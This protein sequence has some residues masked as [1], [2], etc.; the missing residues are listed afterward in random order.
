M[1]NKVRKRKSNV[2]NKISSTKREPTTN[3][4]FQMS[5]YVLLLIFFVIVSFGY[6]FIFP[7][8]FY[9]NEDLQPFENE[10]PMYS[11]LGEKFWSSLISGHYFGLKSSKPNSSI[12]SF[13]WFRNGMNLKIRHW[14]DQNDRLDKY[15]WNYNDLF[16]FGDQLIEDKNLLFNTSFIKVAENSIKSRIIVLDTLKYKYNSIIIYCAAENVHDRIYILNNSDNLFSIKVDGVTDSYTVNINITKGNSFFQSYL[17]TNSTMDQLH[18]TILKNL[19]IFSKN[20]ERLFVISNPNDQINPKSTFVAFQ[21]IFHKSIQIDFEIVPDG[22]SSLSNFNFD[23]KLKFYQNQF[24]QEFEE[25]FSLKKNSYSLEKIEFA[26]S[27]LSST[28]GGISYFHGHS[29]VKSESVQYA[30]PY[31]D[32]QLLTAVPSRSY[33]P[34][35]FL[36]DEGFHQILISIW[37]PELSKKII[38]SWLGLMNKKGWIPREVIL[39]D[40]AMARVPRE[41]LVQYTTNANPP[42]LFLAIESLI[43]NG[44]ADNQWLQDIYPRLKAWYNY[45]NTTQVGK[46]PNSFRW[47]GRISNSNRE[48]NPKTLA[49]GFDDY[50]RSTHPTDDEIHL[51]LRCWMALASRVMEKISKILSNDDYEHFKRYYTI[52]QDN[53]RLEQLHWSSEKEIFCDKGLNSNDVILVKKMKDGELVVER[54]VRSPPKYESITEIGYVSLF[55][56]IMTLI[57]PD[58]SKLLTVMKQIEDPDLLW[59]P[60]GLRSLSKS[61]FY[62]NRYNTG[63]DPPYWRGAI[64]INMN[65]LVLKALNYY[66]HQTGPFQN[67]ARELHGRLKINLVENVF[68]QFK[69]TGYIWEQYSDVNGQGKGQHPFTGW[70]ALI[71]AIMSEQ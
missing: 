28:I 55:P 43:D 31:G 62:Y 10:F 14:C 52:L 37:N 65:Y 59:T 42:T 4:K 63:T 8:L 39:G 9:Q 71:V 30:L 67:T 2:S 53:D 34:R 56:F 46:L 11:V 51:D 17:T 64:W 12:V 1:D 32:M 35:G 24:D 69:D 49:S 48:L 23:D 61:S 40:E 50:P 5:S 26:R 3:Q 27:V 19:Y 36:W 41:F 25:K 16:N 20:G 7:L 18:D 57:E 21:I 38:K 54:Q 6:L 33:F 70:S 47:R 44:N 29:L 13:M 60:Y 45:F 15:Y 58:N 68:K 22:M 66:S